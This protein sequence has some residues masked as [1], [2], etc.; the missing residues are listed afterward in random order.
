MRWKIYFIFHTDKVKPRNYFIMEEIKDKVVYRC[1]HCGRL[2]FNKGGMMIHE[3][4]CKKN[5]ENF[6]ECFSCKFL[7]VDEIKI[8]NTK[9]KR[10]MFCEHAYINTSPSGGKYVE[11][12]TYGETDDCDGSIYAT[13][14]VCEKT[15]KR[16]YWRK[17]VINMKK[18]IKEE[19]MSR[20]DCC[21]PSEC[22]HYEFDG[23][24]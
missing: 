13:Q 16:M 7:S 22:K 19:I 11:G 1:E 20:C 5:P 14:F 21:M 12:C 3:R 23:K 9:G 15:G 10:C 18:K 17:R 6:T 8:N 24:F 2:S 4:G